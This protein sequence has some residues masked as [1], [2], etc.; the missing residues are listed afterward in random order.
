M[1]VCMSAWMDGWTGGWMDEWMDGLMEGCMHGCMMDVCMHAC[2]CANTPV[3][4]CNY[5][6]MI[7]IYIFTHMHT[8]FCIVPIWFQ[9]YTGRYYHTWTCVAS[10]SE[11]VGVQALRCIFCGF[12]FKVR[13]EVQGLG[14]VAV[15]NSGSYVLRVGRAWTRLSWSWN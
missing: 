7:Y 2:M 15:E 11:V 1:C 5:V 3:Y 10:R 8:G 9:G 13:A 4:T 12:K 14:L 6:D